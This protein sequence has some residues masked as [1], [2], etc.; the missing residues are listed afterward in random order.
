MNLKKESSTLRNDVLH[1]E[2]CLNGATGGEI[3]GRQWNTHFYRFITIII[4]II[5]IINI[6]F[7]III[8]II[9]I[10]FVTI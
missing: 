1:W 4:I 6:I 3:R 5:I 9:I 2:H 10:I 8:I 7:V